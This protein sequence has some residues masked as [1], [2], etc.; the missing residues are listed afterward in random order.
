MQYKIEHIK[1]RTYQSLLVP[2]GNVLYTQKS[3]KH[4]FTDG[5]RL[6]DMIEQLRRKTC[7]AETAKFLRLDA[8]LYKI[9]GPNSSP[10]LLA[11]NNRRLWC[12]KE[13]QKRT[14]EVVRVQ[15]NVHTWP[16]VG[17]QFLRNF[18]ATSNGQNVKVRARGQRRA[19]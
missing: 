9:H 10:V 7:N 6:E 3:I 17:L 1:I 16:D 19:C 5:K 18:D 8:M 13:Y 14:H 2:V 4:C 12:L 11:I 15:L